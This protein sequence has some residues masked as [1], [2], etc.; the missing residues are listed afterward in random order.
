[1]KMTFRDMIKEMRVMLHFLHIL[2]F[3]SLTH[4]FKGLKSLSSLKP[5]WQVNTKMGN[6]CVHTS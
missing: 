5:F 4:M 1:M 2:Q 6:M 3:F